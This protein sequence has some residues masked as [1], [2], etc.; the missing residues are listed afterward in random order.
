MLAE[1]WHRVRE[2]EG[3]CLLRFMDSL[4]IGQ[5]AITAVGNGA[6][7]SERASRWL[8]AAIFPVF[9]GGTMAAYAQNTNVRSI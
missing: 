2:H 9:H 3:G 1:P 8:S 4:T 7:R 6:A 5:P